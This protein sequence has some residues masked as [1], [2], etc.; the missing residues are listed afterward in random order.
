MFI[1]GVYPLL[2]YSTNLQN[3]WQILILDALFPIISRI[4]IHCKILCVFDTH[5]QKRTI[6]I[7]EYVYEYF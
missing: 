4:C 2:E 1:I 7:I 3:F 5:M 6:G